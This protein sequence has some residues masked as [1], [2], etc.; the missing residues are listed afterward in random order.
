MHRVQ[1]TS[2]L[3]LF[4]FVSSLRIQTHAFND[5]LLK[6]IFVINSENPISQS[7]VKIQNCTDWNSSRLINSKKVTINQL[8][9]VA[10]VS[11]VE[12]TLD[13]THKGR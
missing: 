1:S 5:D 12:P 11:G 8:L 4:L 6:R 13:G 2:S 9:L 3:L 10:E 7:F